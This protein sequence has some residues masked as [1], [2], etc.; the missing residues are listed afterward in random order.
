MAEERVKRLPVVD[1]LGRV[2]GIVTR[3][4]LLEVYLREGSEHVPYD[5]VNGVAS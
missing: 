1:D 5:R 3:S 2:I 4:G